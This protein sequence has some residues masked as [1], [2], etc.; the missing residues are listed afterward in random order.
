MITS[1]DGLNRLGE[2]LVDKNGDELLSNMIKI[3]SSNFGFTFEPPQRLSYVN[4]L[5]LEGGVVPPRVAV[6]VYSNRWPKTVPTIKLMPPPTG[7]LNMPH[8]IQSARER[9]GSYSLAWVLSPNE[10]QYRFRTNMRKGSVAILR[11]GNVELEVLPAPPYSTQTEWA[12]AGKELHLR[13]LV[14]SPTGAKGDPGEVKLSYTPFGKNIPDPLGETLAPPPGMSEVT[15]DGRIYNIVVH[16]PKHPYTPKKDYVGYLELEAYRGQ[17]RVGALQHRIL[18]RTTGIF[19]YTGEA[20]D[21]NLGKLGVDSI[22]CQPLI[23]KTKP[24]HQGEVDFELE[25]LKILAWG[26]RLEI[27]LTPSARTLE[28][29][30][31]SLP[32]TP[33]EQFEVCL[34]TDDDVASSIAE[35]DKWLELRVSG[36]HEPEHRVPIRLHWQVQ[37]LTFWQRW[38][39]LILSIL[40]I[41]TLLI[42]II[43]FVAPQRFSA[44]LAVTFVPEREDLDEQF[45]LPIKQ[46]KGIRSGFFR[47]AKAFLHA[48]Y[49]ISGKGQGALA[50]LCAEKGGTRITGTGNPLYRETLDGDWENVAQE[51]RRVRPGDIFRIG[52]KGPYFRIAVKGR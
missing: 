34:K 46:W 8:G 35:G 19:H 14:K 29:N 22:R 28:A 12:I 47:N 42:V 48:D 6:I 41:I 33:T 51:R 20:L 27:R 37:G 31:G 43:G 3:F 16:F 32:I 24:Q 7:K 10:G 49:R 50:A 52:E 18:I 1:S 2:F 40:A 44:S 4:R 39:W 11:P 13:V 36:S 38:G 26:H 21:V 5:N 17:A 9:G 30:N 15:P 45:P 25:K 23:F